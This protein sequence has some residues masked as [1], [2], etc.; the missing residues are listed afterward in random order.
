MIFGRKY[1]I[2]SQKKKDLEKELNKL[3]TKG[4]SEIAD[5]LDFI[6]QQPSDEDDYPFADVLDDKEYLEKRIS[7]IR[8]ILSNSQIIDDLSKHSVVEVGS[9]VKVG[10]EGFEEEYLIVSSVEADPLSKKI[11]DES[12]VGKSLLGAKVGDTIEVQL[13]HLQKQFRILNIS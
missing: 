7:E 12:P 6:R 5:R 3:E 9:K 1:K 8:S 11:S 10:F 2:T 13:G 4:R